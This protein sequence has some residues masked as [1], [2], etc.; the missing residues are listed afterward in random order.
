VCT[1]FPCKELSP[2]DWFFASSVTRE[3]LIDAGQVSGFLQTTVSSPCQVY[4]SP[5]STI[6]IFK[7]PSYSE[8]TVFITDNLGRE[9]WR[10]VSSESTVEFPTAQFSAGIYFYRVEEHGQNPDSGKLIIE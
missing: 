1:T 10:K 9:I 6:V 7:F 4:P 3:V 5:S 8:R 2:G